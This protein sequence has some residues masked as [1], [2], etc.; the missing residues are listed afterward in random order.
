LSPDNDREVTAGVTAL[1]SAPLILAP[2]IDA[3][4]IKPEGEALKEEKPEGEALR[5][6]EGKA[7]KEEKPE[8][9]KDLDAFKKSLE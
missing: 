7:L 5:K 6:S 1:I 8:G 4:L 3:P 9:K 2:L